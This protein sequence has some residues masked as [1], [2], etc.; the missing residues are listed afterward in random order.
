MVFRTLVLLS[1]TF[2]IL[3]VG[4]W[5]A[6]QPGLVGPTAILVWTLLALALQLKAP[7]RSFAFTVWV[8]AAVT[9]A[10]FYPD[11]FERW[12][13]FQLSVLIVPLIQVIMFGMGTTLS[14]TDF[15]RVLSVPKAVLIG[16]LLQFTVMPLVG[17]AIALTFG[18]EPAV[19]AGVVLIGSCPGGVASNVMTYLARGNVALSVTM[20]AC[21]TLVSPVMTPLMMVLLAGTMLKIEFV[22][23]MMSILNMIILPIVA[24]LVVNK[25]LRSLNLRGPWLDKL[26]SFVAM[27]A[28]CFIIAIITSLSRDKLLGVGLALIAAAVLHNGLG[29]VFGY[30]GARLLRCDESTCRTVAIEVGLQN[31]GMASGLAVNVLGNPDTALAAAIFGPW[32][33]VSGSVLASWWRSKPVGSPAV[34]PTAA[35]GGED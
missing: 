19:A 3:T 4:L 28:I 27:A 2:A 31:G 8:L 16:L 15:S 1:I 29:Y 11:A 10:M 17:A 23:M 12:G 30:T 5:I 26:L 18:F 13:T 24:G 32:M 34:E 33:N 9:A 20:T 22:P 7:L 6:G 21:S 25:I 35:A 14:L